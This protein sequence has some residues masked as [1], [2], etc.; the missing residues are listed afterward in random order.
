[1]MAGVSMGRSAR[2]ETA[3]GDGRWEWEN[4]KEDSRRDG[5]CGLRDW[6]SSFMMEAIDESSAAACD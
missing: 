2:V 4:G 5:G 1:M 6:G 3:M